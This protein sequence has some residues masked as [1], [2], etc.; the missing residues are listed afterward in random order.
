MYIFYSKKDIINKLNSYL[1]DYNNMKELCN[2]AGNDVNKV[3]SILRLII[4]YVLKYHFNIIKNTN[5]IVDCYYSAIDYKENNKSIL[6]GELKESDLKGIRV[7]SV[8]FINKL[9]ESNI[10][11]RREIENR[12]K[13]F[14]ELKGFSEVGFTY[15]RPEMLHLN[16]KFNY[17]Y[18]GCTGDAHQDYHQL[19]GDERYT[20]VDPLNPLARNYYDNVDSMKYSNNISINKYGNLYDIENG[21][22][23]LVYLLHHEWDVDI[24]CTVTRRIE[25]R[26]FN[27]ITAKL[28]RNYHA[29]IFKNNLLNDDP[30]ILICINNKLYKING[31]RELKDFYSHISDLVYIRKYFIS[32]FGILEYH[33]PV[34][35]TYKKEL[36]EYLSEAG[37]GILDMDFSELLKRFPNHDNQLFYEAYNQLKISFLRS[38]IYESEKDLSKNLLD[39]YRNIVSSLNKHKNNNRIR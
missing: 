4:N 10:I 17:Y 13:H 5:N 31:I 24:P 26:E 34:F 16:K 21:R 29:R 15:A 8:D 6:N 38:R 1:E 2:L 18:Y 19:Y 35:L 30:N 7:P 20:K 32:S 39:E 3:F 23:R 27:I 25:N 9:C 14:D 33:S 12:E 22:H 37:L 28:K 11:E 36:I